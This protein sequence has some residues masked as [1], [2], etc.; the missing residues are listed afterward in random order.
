VTSR[1][2]PTNV[3]S[4]QL[5]FCYRIALKQDRQPLLILRHQRRFPSSSAALV[6]KVGEGVFVFTRMT[7]QLD[8]DSL[9]FFHQGLDYEPVNVH[10]ADAG[11][12]GLE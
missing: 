10:S 4:K 9:V 11:I 6:Q 8:H 2:A 1:A 7:R 12:P 3:I 5:S